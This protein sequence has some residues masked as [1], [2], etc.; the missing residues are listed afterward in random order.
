M[1]HFR[2]ERWTT[3]ARNNVSVVIVNLKKKLSYKIW[4][5]YHIEIWYDFQFF[6]DNNNNKLRRA[7][8]RGVFRTKLIRCFPIYCRNRRSKDDSSFFHAWII[9]SEQLREEK[10]L[11]ACFACGGRFTLLRPNSLYKADLFRGNSRC[12]DSRI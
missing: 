8:N 6:Y 9:R 1:N 7:I 5:I 12:P 2:F 11:L 10:D 4:N 3:F